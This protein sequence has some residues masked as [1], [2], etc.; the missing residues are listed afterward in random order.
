MEDKK[1]FFTDCSQVILTSSERGDTLTE[2]EV[3]YACEQYDNAS[4]AFFLS[5]D[6]FIFSFSFPTLRTKT[7]QV[8]RLLSIFDDGPGDAFT[9]E[10]DDSLVEKATNAPGS[11]GTSASSA[12]AAY[13]PT[14]VGST[15]LTKEDMKAILKV[16]LAKS[17]IKVTTTMIRRPIQRLVQHV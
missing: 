2:T 1:D 4:Q 11:N 13:V 9:W 12:G 5:I 3:R 17:S 7:L 16:R 14:P 15:P 10:P 8:K 6:S